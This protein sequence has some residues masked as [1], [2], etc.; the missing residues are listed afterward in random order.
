MKKLRRPYPQHIVLSSAEAHRVL[1]FF[2]GKGNVDLPVA[3]LY[4]EDLEFAQAVLIEGVEAT[5]KLNFVVDVV[6]LFYKK[7]FG[8]IKLL[9]KGLI[10]IA[11]E[12]GYEGWFRFADE[13]DLKNP[14]IAITVRNNI[15]RNLKSA[16]H[17]RVTDSDNMM[18]SRS[19]LK[20]RQFGFKQ[21]KH[22]TKN[23]A[24]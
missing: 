18:E 20:I 21:P 1:T 2:F 14:K 7:G 13:G 12:H 4:R 15:R 10:K 6:G 8:N 17:G 9:T 16:W 19:W 23:F 24:V 3:R 11:R 5:A 22:L